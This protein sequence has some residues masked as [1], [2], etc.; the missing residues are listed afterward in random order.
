MEAFSVGYLTGFDAASPY[1]WVGFLFLTLY[2]HPLGLG[3][4]GPEVLCDREEAV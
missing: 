2:A 3:G 1:G 4:V